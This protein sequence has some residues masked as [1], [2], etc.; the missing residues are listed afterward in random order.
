MPLANGQT[1]QNR[2]RIV[3]LIGQG[4][5]GAV[6]RAWDLR[7][8]APCA[9]KENLD[10]SAEAQRQFTREA[11]ILANLRHPNLPRV[12]DYFSV[13]GQ[14]QYLVM[15]FIEGESLAE[16]A[17]RNGPLP[18]AQA[19]AW[20][21]QICAALTYLHS[22]NPPIIHRDVKPDNITITSANQ[23]ILVDFGAFK[24]YA[25][26][27]KTTLAA[28]VVSPG[29]A[30]IEQYG[31]GATDAR[32]DVYAVGAVLYTILSG[33]EPPESIA[34]LVGT[35]LPDL[36]SLNPHLRHT[37]AQTISRAMGIMP[38]QRPPTIAE[39]Q[40]ALLGQSPPLSPTLTAPQ[41]GEIGVYAAGSPD[42]QNPA[43]IEWVEIPA[44]EF[45]FGD[46]KERHY[47][48]KAYKIGK[49]P[50][51]NAQYKRFLDANPQHPAPAEWDK[52]KREYA[53]GKTN[54]PVVNVSWDDAQAF[55]RWA[56][57]R[58][59]SETEWEKAARGTDGRIYPWGND[60][61]SGKYCNSAEARLGGTTP[62]NDFP[63]GVSSYKVWDMSGNVWEWTGSSY[64]YKTKVVRGGAW[65]HNA[66]FVRAA[67]RNY[68]APADRS[69]NII[70]F[71]CA[72]D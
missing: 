43:G 22:Q 60:W 41:S 34:R 24:V 68:F 20:I 32:T 21:S 28:R 61:V 49:Y 42:P 25:P 39:L 69:L 59:P 13:A 63:A 14:G 29:Y 70:G 55:C 48:R 30:P 15:D 6:Y 4:G 54:H 46:K 1:V 66:E 58:L 71:R 52:Q 8:S 11:S 67:N 64:D 27:L 23:A 37:L 31:M 40:A 62:V 9:L 57:C 72:Q 50:V 7:L 65:V 3:K 38:D 19:V 35:P 26:H 2:Y 56:N 12:I 44:G 45:L 16:K 18:E 33:Q 10:S 51:T 47:I 17:Q 53:A 36:L 5:F